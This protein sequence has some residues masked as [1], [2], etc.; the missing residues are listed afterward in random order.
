MPPLSPTV[1]VEDDFGL[2]ISCLR[3]FLIILSNEFSL[4]SINVSKFVVSNFCDFSYFSF[5]G[6]FDLDF[7][8][9]DRDFFELY[10]SQLFICTEDLLLDFYVLNVIFLETCIDLALLNFFADEHVKGVSISF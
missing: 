2:L 4:S 3:P 10:Y 1:R 7:L 6:V 5:L 8:D 9:F